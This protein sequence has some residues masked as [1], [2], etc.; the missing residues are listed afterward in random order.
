[1]AKKKAQQAPELR[2]LVCTPVYGDSVKRGYAHSVSQ[3]MAFFAQVKSDVPKQ[4]DIAMAYSSNLVENRHILV[5]RAFQFGATHLLFWDS[6][7][8]APP[9]A[10]VKLVN[11][12]LPIVAINYA[13]KEPEARPTA[14]IDTDSYIGP[15]WTQSQHKGLQEVSSCGFGLMLIETSVLQAIETPL[16]QFTQVGTE[17]IKTETE[18][19]YFCHKA[20]K[21]G[22]HIVIDHDL[23]KQCAHL[24]DW[25]FTCS[26]SDI[27]QAAKQK[28]YSDMPTS[29]PDVPH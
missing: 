25:E 16:F 10:I 5:S 20:Q 8:K 23:S 17:G 11:H 28:L 6:D 26:M 19:V 1:M 2:I 9:D 27:A 3:A 18:D 4:I 29:G 14:F 24:G 15:C 13:K 21:A 12:H 22:F 7:I